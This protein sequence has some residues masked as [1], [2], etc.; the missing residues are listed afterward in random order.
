[1]VKYLVS[2]GADIRSEN[3]EAVQLASSNG[4]LEMVKYLVSL[5]ADI[6]SLTPY[7]QKYI[8]FCNKIEDKM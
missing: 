5:G 6:R 1:M 2:Q 7:Q 4:H 3:D 8:L